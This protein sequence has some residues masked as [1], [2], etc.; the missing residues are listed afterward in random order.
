MC[1]ALI[2]TSP[3]S[4][5][6]RH[7]VYRVG[8]IGLSAAALMVRATDQLDARQLVRCADRR[9]TDRSFLQIAGGSGSSR[10]GRSRRYR[11]AGAPPSRCARSRGAAWCELGRRQ[12]HRVRHRR[13]ED[14]SLARVGGGGE[15]A[16]LTTPDAAQREGDHAFPSVL[17]GGR[18]VLF[19]ITAGE[20]N[21]AQVAVLDLTTG[22]RKTL[23]RGGARPNTSP[24]IGSGQAGVSDLRDSRHAASCALRPGEARGL[25]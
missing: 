8:G 25:E 10:P 2:A 11:S 22:R 20:A 7:L 19:T 9:T 1:Q 15:P 14:R 5:D 21:N 6:G 3:L 24:S 13:L 12:L 16:V 17:P 4:P 23:V 18:G